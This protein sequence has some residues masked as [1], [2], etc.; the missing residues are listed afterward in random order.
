[1]YP[2]FFTSLGTIGYF[3][4]NL[5]EYYVGEYYL[6]IINGVTEGSV[7]YFSGY[8]AVYIYGWD[9]GFDTFGLGIRGTWVLFYPMFLALIYQNVEVLYDILHWKK[10]FNMIV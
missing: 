9:L 10:P 3:I 5:K 6:Q 8:T 4:F 2:F 1:M 7:L